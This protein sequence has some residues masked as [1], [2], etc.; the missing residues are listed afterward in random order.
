MQQIMSWYS[1]STPL[2][3]GSEGLPV[4]EEQFGHHM[5]RIV[6]SNVIMSTKQAFE[7]TVGSRQNRS[8]ST[9][10]SWLVSLQVKPIKTDSVKAGA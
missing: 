10:F 5:T 9:S 7:T 6:H 3:A 8:A 2:A 4:S 1:P